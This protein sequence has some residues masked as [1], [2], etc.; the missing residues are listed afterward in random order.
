MD[1]AK[2]EPV[3][4]GRCSL[5]EGLAVAIFAAGRFKEFQGLACALRFVLPVEEAAD[6]EH[7]AE[8]PARSRRSPADWLIVLSALLEHGHMRD[9]YFFK[10]HFVAASGTNRLPEGLSETRLKS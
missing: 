9:G 4:S 3:D 7:P 10:S 8:T 5:F 1:L 2:K 6:R